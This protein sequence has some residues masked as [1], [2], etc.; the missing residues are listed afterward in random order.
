M[1]P[2]RYKALRNGE[3]RLLDLSA[4]ETSSQLSCRI[5]HCSIDDPPLFEALSYTWGPPG[6]SHTISCDNEDICVT[7]NLKSALLRLRSPVLQRKLWIDQICINQDE[8]QERNEQV[9]LMGDIY[10]KAQQVLIWLG[11]EDEDSRFGLNY[12]QILLAELQPVF[13]NGLGEIKFSDLIKALGMPAIKGGAWNALG[14]IF[15]RTWFRR[16][17]VV[18]EAALAAV[19]TVMC[20]SQTV[21][22]QDLVKV[23]QCQVGS[24][25]PEHEAH[26]SMLAIET[27]RERHERRLQSPFINI[28]LL[29]SDFNCTDPRDKIFGLLGLTTDAGD[30]MLA[31]DYSLSVQEVYGKV[32]R[33]LMTRDKSL[34]V[35]G[36]VKEP[37]SLQGLPTWTPDWSIP[38]ATQKT[39]GSRF[40]GRYDAAQSTQASVQFSDDLR[41]LFLDGVV[42]DSIY[43]LGDILLSLPFHHLKILPQWESMVQSAQ[44]YPTGE[45][46][47]TVLWR[48]LIADNGI[49]GVKSDQYHRDLY[50]SWHNINERNF[51]AVK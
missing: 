31:P 44:P 2:Y 24:H 21:P 23:C 51:S 26:S 12:V 39:L 42:V 32:T 25:D 20:G 47:T 11:E 33:F 5:V 28:L 29:C 9:A 15:E 4:G 19:A 43:A 30:P 3:I 13:D 38:L 22:W 37:K 34:A 35:L 27:Q 8:L 18:Q 46:S 48:M 49:R 10:R 36:D 1:A 6:D 17:W 41:T 45:D 14:R 7:V 50:D 40:R 16:L